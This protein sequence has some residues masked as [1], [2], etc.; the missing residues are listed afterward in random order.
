MRYAFF[1]NTKLWFWRVLLPYFGQNFFFSLNFAILRNKKNNWQWNS[2]RTH[3]K[4]KERVTQRTHL[5]YFFTW[6]ITHI[7]KFILSVHSVINLI[8]M[9]IWEKQNLRSCVTR[10]FFH[11]TPL[12]ETKNLFSETETNSLDTT[13]LN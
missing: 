5:R 1:S 9:K 6:A 10:S 13:C 8:F 2:R 12:L 7:L 4:R 3:K 11:L